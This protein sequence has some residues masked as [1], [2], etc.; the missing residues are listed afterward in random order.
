MFIPENYISVS[1]QNVIHAAI[2]AVQNP[3]N[4]SKVCILFHITRNILINIFSV[5]LSGCCKHMD[6]S[7]QT[8]SRDVGNV[9]CNSGGG[10]I[11]TK[12]MCLKVYI[13]N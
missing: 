13:I 9:D 2:A 7:L 11:T 12:S 4:V 10:N 3:Q 1:Y 5:K 6:I 8:C